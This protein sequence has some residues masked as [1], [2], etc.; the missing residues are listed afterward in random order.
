MQQAQVLVYESDGRLA[1]SLRDLSQ[2]R[3][4][5]LR[6]LRHVQACLSALR[7]HGPAVLVIKLGKDLDRE[8]SLLEQVTRSF[9]DT[10][11]LVVGDLQATVLAGL[12]WDLGAAYVLVPPQ[13]GELLRELVV[14]FLPAAGPP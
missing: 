2:A 14:G 7:R 10:A 8:F 1:D 9:P 12:A 5:R 13:P 11:T 4:F 3:S 6:E